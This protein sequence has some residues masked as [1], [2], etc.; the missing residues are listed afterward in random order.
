MEPILEKEMPLL[1]DYG[2]KGPY[3]RGSTELNDAIEHLETLLSKNA[4]KS[5]VRV[6]L[7]VKNKQKFPHLPSK[8]LVDMVSEGTA[9]TFY[10]RAMK[11]LMEGFVR[12]H[13]EFKGRWGVLW[14]PKE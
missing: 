6:R 3:P 12:R 7:D 5:M 14:E 2:E 13:R 9:A 8:M 1:C 11:E 10:K 4:S